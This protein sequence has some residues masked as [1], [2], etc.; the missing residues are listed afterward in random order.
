MKQHTVKAHFGT[1]GKVEKVSL[2]QN[3]DTKI[4]RVTKKGK[5]FDGEKQIGVLRRERL[6]WFD[7]QFKIFFN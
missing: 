5:V 2:T 3:G 4:Y 6:K 1:S 7:N